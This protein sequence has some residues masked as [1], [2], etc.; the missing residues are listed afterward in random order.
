MK[1]VSAG[2]I[3]LPFPSFSLNA[4]ATTQVACLRYRI[5]V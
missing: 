5:A 4:G 3:G 1:R 2:P